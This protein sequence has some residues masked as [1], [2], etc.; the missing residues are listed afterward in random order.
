M[1]RRVRGLW[2]EGGHYV[3]PSYGGDEKKI[4]IDV[5]GGIGQINLVAD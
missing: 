4:R 5:H 2:Q 3:S 1:P